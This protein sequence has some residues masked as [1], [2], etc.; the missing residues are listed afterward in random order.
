[1]T[2]KSKNS[3]K[4]GL[5]AEK[6]E[7][8]SNQ[9][10]G[11]DSFFL[12]SH[13]FF[14]LAKKIANTFSNLNVRKKATIEENENKLNASAEKLEVVS[15]PKKATKKEAKQKVFESYVENT[16]VLNAAGQMVMPE[17]E[18]YLNHK[19]NRIL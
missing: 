4:N 6:M 8:Q 1:M 11:E 13:H 17:S 9:N 10:V 15:D 7:S 2:T 16:K 12:Q 18:N 3:N 5:Q 14:E 19:R